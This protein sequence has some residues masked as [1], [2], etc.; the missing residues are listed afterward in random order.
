M[1]LI[2]SRKA[3]AVLA[4]AF[5]ICAVYVFSGSEPQ[6][7]QQRS[8]EP[9]R[10][11]LYAKFSRPDSLTADIR[12]RSRELARVEITSPGD[13]AKVERSAK[14]V[15]DFG[16]FVVV[17]K[18]KN[19]DLASAGLQSKKLDGDVHMPA[20]KFEPLTQLQS[21]T[22]K[23]EAPE[24]LNGYD[25]YVVQFGGIATDEWLDSL[26]D[27]GVEVLQY[28]PD[29]AFL[30]YG[31]RSSVAKAAGHSRV[32][33]AGRYAPEHKL[34]TVLKEQLSAARTQTPTAGR[35]SEIEKT[36]ADSAIFDV[37]VFARADVDNAASEIQ[38]VT[39]GRI[40]NISRLPNNYF[41]VVRIEIPLDRV[42]QVTNIPDVIR[43]D[44]WSKPT[45]EDERA[46]QIVAGNYTGVSS[47]AGPGYNP[48][49]QFGVNG[50]GV[51]VSVVD[52]GVSLPTPFPTAAGFYITS[53]NT[54][55]GPLHGAA[56]GATG[57]HGHLNASIIA[58][59][60]PFAGLDPTGY[61]YGLGIAPGANI[62]NIPL[63]T[64]GYAASESVSY[65]DTLNTAG[66]NGVK[67]FI[68]N[69]SWGNGLNSNVY[70]SY[71]AQFDGF[72]RDA[73]LAPTIDPI[74]LVFSAG[75][76]G[77]GALSLTRP[78]AAK[79]MISV[80][81]SENL[82]PEFN[83]TFA[84]NMDDLR[85]TSSRGP[86]AD[87]RI[88]PDI[89]APGSYVT[90]SRAGTDCSSVTSCFDAN[91]S[92]SIG[93]SHA[94]PQVAGAAALFTQFWRNGH[95]GQN[96]SPALAKAAILTTGQ[97]MNG[98]TT[99]TATL[100]NGNEGWGRI[101][102]K[103]MLNT[104]VPMQYVNETTVLSN[105]GDT[106][107][108]NGSVG[109][110]SKPVRIGL[111]W[112]D[113][114][115]AADPALVNNLNLTV[116]VGA[117]TY[118]GNV[119][120]GGISTTGGSF[121]TLNN[122]ENVWLP[123]GIPAGTPISIQVTAASLNGDG[124]LGNGDAT[125]QHFAIVGYNV[126]ESVVVPTVRSPFDFDG[127][128]KTDI[129]IF[130][131]NAQQWWISHSSTGSVAALAFGAGVDA[132]VPVPSDYTGDGKTD[133]ALWRNT[134]GSWFILRSEDNTFFAIPFGAN[135]DVPAPGDFDGD[136]RGDLTVYRPSAG[137]WFSI[138]SSGGTSIRTFGI[139]GDLPVVGDYDG[140]GLSDVAIYR[141]AAGEWW[142]A[143]SG[144]GIVAF[145]FGAAGDK[146]V[147]ADFTG[148]GRTDAAFW[149][150]SNGTWYILRSEDSSYFAIPFGN[151][152]DTPAPGDYDGD[153]RSDIAVFRP[154]SATWFINRSTAG[155]LI[156]NFGT[157][158]DLP[159]PSSFVR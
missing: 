158:G 95:A 19:V 22:V 130:R 10:G 121:D 58:G 17:S 149:R 3:L 8:A 99:N 62:I 96:P 124:V 7:A 14:I 45:K 88:K 103:F 65:D 137:T 140:D 31:D 74:L 72:V 20:G 113:P 26:R 9:R 37:A 157:S 35:V 5:A 97:E 56:V 105:V 4:T 41:N 125:D 12:N 13:R 43:V 127:D 23:P 39:G 52:D 132:G 119:F 87:G 142:I 63:L 80:G 81:N 154:S 61:N 156:T 143:R 94:A 2:P 82:R 29:Q 83:A 98:L 104:G 134:D 66:P 1:N 147:A 71:T 117:N 24:N 90:G 59:A 69:N 107:S 25:Y 91:H 38:Q 100:P 64:S 159:L 102:M 54:L 112:T 76:N 106:F 27:A 11:E 120:S 57:G 46:A 141:P 133:I 93:T 129:S 123:A 49:A 109:N 139:V 115:A 85:G 40:K 51:T 55:N 47:I 36:S 77:P 34:P 155:T 135:G 92:Y 32:R 131:P 18:S 108:L 110:A 145:Q 148:D 28:L 144:G 126:G 101:N 136:G 42:E 153:G 73:S 15:E 75:N 116:T 79:N 128:G 60:A 152:G 70:D 86:T 111:V 84:D 118:R 89:I 150:P 6:M 33:W 138:L 48:L 68:S 50:Q 16:S 67:G 146:A 44:A 151:S 53:L 30:V 122:V 78:K 114:P 21:V